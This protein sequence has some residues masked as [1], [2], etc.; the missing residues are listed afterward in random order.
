[1]TTEREW[2]QFRAMPRWD[3]ECDGY[4][5]P[6]P[7]DTEAW[8]MR[9]DPRDGTVYYVTHEATPQVNVWCPGSQLH[10]HLHHLMQVHSR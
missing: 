5:L 2:T 10:R 6:F 1:M 3:G 4:S 8:D 7:E 9:R